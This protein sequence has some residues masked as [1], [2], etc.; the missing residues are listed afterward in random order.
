[1]IFKYFLPFHRLSFHFVKYTK[2][3]INYVSIKLG[4]KEVWEMLKEKK[5]TS[6]NYNV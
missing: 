1:M 4:K 6:T 5:E 2:L 3:Y